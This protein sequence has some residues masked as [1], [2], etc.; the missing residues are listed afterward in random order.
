MS[1][2]PNTQKRNIIASYLP[3]VVLLRLLHSY[4]DVHRLR[5]EEPGFWRAL[6]ATARCFLL[7]LPHVFLVVSNTTVIVAKAILC[8]SQ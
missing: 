2:L 8:E 5:E 3:S 4:G 6:R 1:S 7:Q